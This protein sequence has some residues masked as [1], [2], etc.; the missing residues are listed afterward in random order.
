MGGYEN[1]PLGTIH[2]STICKRSYCIH[3]EQNGPY[4]RNMPKS[5]AEMTAPLATAK[6]ASS[7]YFAGED[8][9]IEE[10]QFEYEQLNAFDQKVAYANALPISLAMTFVCPLVFPYMV[11]CQP[12]NV[13]D[14]NNATHVCVTRD[15]I[16]Y[17]VDKHK[18]N[19]RMSM[20][21]V[22]RTMKTVPF[23]KITDCDIQEPAGRT[24]CCWAVENTITVVNVDT[25]SSGGPGQ[26]GLPRHE[27][28]IRG[29]VDP[30]A[31][32]KLVWKM[33]REGHGTPSQQVAAPRDINMSRGGNADVSA[34]VQPL[35]AQNKLLEQ[36]NAMLNEHTALLRKIA[37]AK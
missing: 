24:A 8:G 27:V 3:I 7:S 20:C 34:L 13:V 35:M 9:L 26:E 28:Q 36:Q 18:A 29:L 5:A 25:A 23:D 15:G 1:R 2:P 4:L 19:C 11:I 6:V 33:K 37:A 32:K 12:Q 22:G 21:D 30:H 10:F 14:R 16:R 31:F 17:S